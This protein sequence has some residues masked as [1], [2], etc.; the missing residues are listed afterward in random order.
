MRKKLERTYAKNAAIN[1]TYQ[2]KVNEKHHGEKLE[3]IMDGLYQMF[4]HALQEAR[5]DLVG[6]NLCRVV[7]QPDGLHDPIIVPLQPWDQLDSNKVMDTIEKVLNSL[8][9]LA[10]DE[11]MNIAVGT[12]DL[13]K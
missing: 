7:I 5:G 10:I 4:E 13:P 1:R 2:V 6:N 11:S 8:Q 9:N 12:V 3:D